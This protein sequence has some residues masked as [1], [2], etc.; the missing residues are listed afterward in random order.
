M[1]NATH[2]KELL[3]AGLISPKHRF[4]QGWGHRLEASQMMLGPELE[5]RTAADAERGRY[6]RLRSTTFPRPRP[7]QQLLIAAHRSRRVSVE[8]GSTDNIG[9]AQK[10]N[11]FGA[12]G[13]VRELRKDT[14]IHILYVYSP[15]CRVL[16][17]LHSQVGNECMSI[18]RMDWTL[19]FR[20]CM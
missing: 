9:F 19:C 12:A 13:N 3:L 1:Q 4:P 14:R 16:S 8:R 17:A 20:Y 15:K 11:S 5:Q 2:L 7:A 10:N 6:C 18:Y